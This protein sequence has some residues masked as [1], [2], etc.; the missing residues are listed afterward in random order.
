MCNDT[1]HIDVASFTIPA[2][3]AVSCSAT[4][5][6]DGAPGDACIDSCR[7]QG[8]CP[9]GAACTAIGS[10]GSNRVGL[11]TAS[12][13][14]GGEA[15][16]PCLASPADCVW[17]DCTSAGVCSRDCTADGVCPSGFTCTPGGA[18]AVSRARRSAA[19]NN[20]EERTVD[21]RA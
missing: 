14:G 21:R 5:T 3:P 6:T 19:V 13:V 4:T 12:P 10:V 18:P 17:G 20:L 15:G 1:L 11:C 9:F 16:A 2:P 7:Y 8:G